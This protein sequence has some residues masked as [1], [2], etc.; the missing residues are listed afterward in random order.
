MNSNPNRLSF[1]RHLKNQSV[2]S[3]AMVTIGLLQWA[4]W[5]VPAQVE[6]NVRM[7]PRLTVDGG[8]GWQRIE[9]SAA[10]GSGAAWVVATNFSSPFVFGGTVTWYD[11]N[12]VEVKERYYRTVS[13]NLTGLVWISPGA[14][15]MGSLAGEPGRQADEGPATEVT[16][17]RGFWMGQQE[18]TQGEYR[19]VMGDNPSSFTGDDHLPVE[20]VSWSEATNYCWKLTLEERNAGRIG[21]GQ[22]YRLPTEAQWEY[23]DDLPGTNLGNYAWYLEDSGET[24]PAGQKTPNAWGLYDLYGNVWEWCLDWYGAYA[25][26]QVVDPSGPGSGTERVK[27]GGAWNSELADCRSARRSHAG[28]VRQFSTGLRVVLVSLD[29]TAPGS[30][31]A[32]ITVELIPQITL[33]GTPGFY[34]IE[35]AEIINDVSGWTVIHIA[36]VSSNGVSNFYDTTPWRGGLRYFRVSSAPIWTNSVWIAPGMFTMG[37]PSS[38]VDRYSDEGPQTQVTISQGF[39]MGKYEVTQAEYQAVMGS[40]PSYFTGDVKRPVD[41]V[42][43]DDATNYCGQLTARERSA[44]RL[45]TGYAYRLP[46][47]A[48]WEYACRAGTTTRFSYGDDSG[49][50]QLGNYAWYYSN[51]GGTTH[52]VGQ[53]QPNAWGLYDMYGNVWEWCLDWYSGSLPG[54]SVTDPRGPNTGSRRVFRGGGW[55][56][57]GWL[58]RSAIRNDF[59]W[60]GD[61]DYDLGFRPVLAPGP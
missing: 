60:P 9:R 31:T 16:L 25:G 48:E 56:G 50:V 26:G 23:G 32:K 1:M 6:L 14:F 61:G 42:T 34:W 53:K 49:Y 55:C 58:C 44:G 45:P 8:Q 51:C 5:T 36:T 28:D 10:L 27:R 22:E 7:I 4:V 43:W 21:A 39:V 12:V 59:Y 18:V 33:K 19:A 40:N 41:Q 47:E 46:T 38:E 2:I 11:T 30:P 57:L 54:G 24:H 15:I 20:V 35:R 3:S 17:S 29:A 37:S 13:T 52:P